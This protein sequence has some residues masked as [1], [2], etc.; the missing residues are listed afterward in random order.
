[1]RQRQFLKGHNHE[2]TSL[3]FH[4]DFP[5]VFVSADHGG[6]MHV[7][8]LPFGTPID[9]LEHLNEEIIMNRMKFNKSSN[10]GAYGFV[11]LSISNTERG[12]SI[13][14]F[15]PMILVV[16]QVCFSPNGNTITSLGNDRFI[17]F[18]E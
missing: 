15:N 6:K 8:G 17:Q 16:N 12:T 7:W 14:K 13:G 2:V 1:M 4:P 10:F 11:D 3:S 18:W 9:I 5:N